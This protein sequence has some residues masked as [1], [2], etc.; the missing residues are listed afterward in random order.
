M[1]I[2]TRLESIIKNSNTF[3]MLEFG[4]CDGYHTNIFLDLMRSS[5]KPFTFHS[6]EPEKKNFEIC[7]RATA[8]HAGLFE[9]W[10]MAVGAENGE[11]PFY[12]SS[13]NY[14]GSSSIRAPKLVTSAWPTMTF[15][16]DIVEVITL[17][18]F[19]AAHLKDKKIDF[20]WADVQ[21]A[22]GDLITGG[23]NTWKNVH[24]L[25]VEYDNSELYSG[26]KIGLDSICAMLP[27]FTVVEDYGGDVLLRNKWGK[28]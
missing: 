13:R 4:A 2:L 12:V 8:A 20:I 22:A 3:T 10:N 7:E 19:A 18:A 15:T 14:Y 9:L 17:D 28:K 1:N 5:Q 23:T 27:G 25:F 24:Y 26:E 11:K 21:G 16:K 6:F